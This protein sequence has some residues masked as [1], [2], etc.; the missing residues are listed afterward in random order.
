[1]DPF[2]VLVENQ[3]K[4]ISIQSISV[5]GIK[6]TNHEFLKQI[7][8]PLLKAKNL[9]DAII[10]ARNVAHQMNRLD[11]FKQTDVVFKHSDSLDVIHGLDV[12]FS[13][14]EA[15]RLYARTGVDFGNNDSNMV[16]AS[17]AKLECKFE[18][19]KCPWKR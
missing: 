15:P 19:T 16:S 7:T 12:V 5:D 9:G 3:S 13:V 6:V 17:I 18:N 1:M 4:P 10:G 14:E 11:I 2:Q 8:A